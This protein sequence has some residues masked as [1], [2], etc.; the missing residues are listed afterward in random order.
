MCITVQLS[1]MLML[2]F[3]IRVKIFALY[4]A[5]VFSETVSKALYLV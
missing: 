5:V 4:L 3:V 1:L 2:L